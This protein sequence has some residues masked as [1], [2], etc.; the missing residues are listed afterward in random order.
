MLLLHCN[1]IVSSEGDKEQLLRQ[2]LHC[3]TPFTDAGDR[4]SVD[5]E[6]DTIHEAIRIIGIFE[7]VETDERGFSIIGG[8]K[9]V[10]YDT[11]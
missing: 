5:V 9:E 3:D 10:S 7:A 1:A 6:C 11:G 8:R 4:V 2:L